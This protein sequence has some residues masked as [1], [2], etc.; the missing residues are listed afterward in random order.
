MTT[1][2]L[3]PPSAHS[4]QSPEDDSPASPPEK[5]RTRRPPP[6]RSAS[7]LTA[8]LSAE[9]EQ[10]GGLTG[11]GLEVLVDEEAFRALADEGLLR[12]QTQLLAA[13]VLLRAVI[14]PCVG[15]TGKHKTARWANTH[16]PRGI[17]TNL[18]GEGRP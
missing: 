10:R 8:T 2:S 7:P 15:H 17:N 3:L 12:V 18:P 14:H 5:E 6:Q 11:A 16:R 13:M 4:M 1:V 9:E